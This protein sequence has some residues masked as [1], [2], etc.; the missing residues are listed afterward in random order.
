M[1]S[2]KTNPQ[3]RELIP[4]LLPHTK[5]S[6][7]IPSQYLKDYFPNLEPRISRASDAE[8]REAWRIHAE[9]ESCGGIIP[10]ATVVAPVGALLSL[11]LPEGNPEKIEKLSALDTIAFLIDDIMDD[12]FCAIVE[13]YRPIERSREQRKDMSKEY[14]IKL[15]QMK[16]KYFTQL[17]HSDED[18]INFVEGWEQWHRAGLETNNLEDIEFHSLDDYIDAR[19]S[20]LGAD[21]YV[22]LV[23]Y[24]HDIVL[25]EEEKDKL[26]TINLIVY[27]AG[28]LINDYYSVEREWAAHAA[29]KKPGEPKSTVWIVMHTHDV[30]LGEAKEIVKEKY[31]RLE[32]D[33][34]QERKRLMD[35]NGPE[36]VYGRLTSYLQYILTGTALFSMHGPRYHL[37]PEETPHYPRPE[38]KIQELPGWRPK[39]SLPKEVNGDKNGCQNGNGSTGTGRQSNGANGNH[40]AKAWLSTYSKLSDEIILEPFEYIKSLPSK[41]IRNFAIEALD[42]WYRVPQSSLDVIMNVVDILHSSSLIIDDIEDGSELRRGKPSAHMIYG[43]P[44]AINASNFLFVKALEEVRKLGSASVDIYTDELHNLHVGQAFD[45]HWTFLGGCPSEQEY[46]KMVDG[47]TGGLF[48]MACRLVKDQA[49]TNQDLDVEDLMTLMGRFFQ[50]RDDYQNLKSKGYSTAKGHLSDL[51]EGKYSFMLIH[52]LNHAKDKQL[53]SLLQQRSRQGRLTPEQKT[54]VMKHLRTTKSMEFTLAVLEELQVAVHERL[55]EVESRLELGPNWII[56][57]IMARLR[58]ASPEM[59]LL[60]DR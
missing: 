45:L 22:A 38:H 2:I 15:N 43:S 44:Q 23:P 5:N 52:A 19:L 46:I 18:A 12:D 54:L 35:E 37:T 33:F 29:L 40:N 8:E 42:Y 26:D 50:I 30:T 17:L 56:R 9:W 4:P 10:R 39:A 60:V 3:Q 11:T 16:A 25:S 7:P 14:T 36:S 34:L 57:A 31:F 53:A 55:E 13:N 59:R 49:T 21:S 51:D 47:K 27:Q 41:K 48:R 24:I 28:A 1:P 6:L 32:R 58:V 20:S